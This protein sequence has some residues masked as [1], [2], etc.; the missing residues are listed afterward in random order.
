MLDGGLRLLI[1]DPRPENDGVYTCVAENQVG[2]TDLSFTIT[3]HG[4]LWLGL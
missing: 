4:T 2:V 1:P 3:V